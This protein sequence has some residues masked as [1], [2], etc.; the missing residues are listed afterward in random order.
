MP[1]PIKYSTGSETLALKKGNFYIGTGD[2][3]KGP[4]ESTG[5]WNGI[6]PPTS[7]YTIYLSKETQGPSAYVAP[8]DN[9]LIT[10]TNQISGQNYTGVTQCLTYFASQTDKMV[11]NTDYPSIVTDGLVLNLDAGFV[12]SYPRSGTTWSDISLSG[13]S[14]TLTNGPTYV[15]D[16]GGGISFDGANDYVTLGNNVLKYQDSFTVEV[17]C[18][19]TSLPNNPGSACSARHPIVYNH[20]YGYN[21]LVSS[22][23]ILTWNIYNTSSQSKQ[24]LS[25]NSVIGNTYFHGV[26]I[27]NGA[28]ISVYVNGVFQSSDILSTNQVYYVNL[29]FTIGGFATC[30]PNKFYA[31]GNINNVKIYNRALTDDEILQ[32]YNA[33]KS[34]FGL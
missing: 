26:G 21:L 17:W 33:T 18:K 20:D 12:P 10:I 1:N 19:F 11:L 7:G 5:Y 13:N 30:G 27:K 14:G 16:N 28:T 9:D 8:T 24:V 34:R 29:P 25:K 6:S 31:N 22:T 32:N 15:S 4:T 3:G 23:G 2:V